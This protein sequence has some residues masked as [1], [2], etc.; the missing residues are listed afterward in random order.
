MPVLDGFDE[1]PEGHRRAAIGQ[2]STL[3]LPVILT[4]RPGEYARAAHEV[5]AVG[6]AAAIML[7]DLTLEET[8]EYLRQSTGKP[9][10]HAWDVVFEQLRTAPDDHASRNLTTVLSSPLMV[11]LARTVYNDNPGHHPGELLDAERFPG[12]EDLEDHLLDVYVETVYTLRTSPQN[13]RRPN[14]NPDQTRRWLGYLAKHLVTLKTHDLTWWQLPATLQRHTRILTTTATWGIVGGL[15]VI[16][17]FMVIALGS[18]EVPAGGLGYRPFIAFLAGLVR[19]LPIGLTVGLIKELG[20]SRGRTG[21]GPERLRLT[22]RKRSRQK[23]CPRIYLKKSLSELIG[24]LAIGLAIALAIWFPAGLYLV[25]SSGFTAELVHDAV[26]VFVSGSAVGLVYGLVSVGVFALG[27][28]HDLVATDPWTLLSRDRTVTLVRTT[29]LALMFGILFGILFG[30]VFGIG[31]ADR[32]LDGLTT[33]LVVGFGLV[34]GLVHLV[35]SVWGSW[36]L[37]VRLWLPLTGRL[38]W[39]PK[40]FLEDAH[41]RGVLRRTGAVYQFRHARLRDHLAA[42]DRS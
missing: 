38:P 39:R 34:V 1:I 17:V 33:G 18:R 11:M 37:F 8:H 13:S 5:K 6:G 41:D 24:G 27:D 42:Q 15:G 30:I 22:L 26:D 7:E 3:D 4:S 19:A 2:I 25:L 12:V 20:F 14:W 36:L 40:R 23:R 9:R 16:A 21:R 29:T 32:S 31:F 28:N 10:S 35:L